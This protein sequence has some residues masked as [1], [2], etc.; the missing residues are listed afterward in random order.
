MV[1]GQKWS[2]DTVD[3]RNPAPADSYR[4]PLVIRFFT[5]GAG[6]LPSTASPIGSVS[7]V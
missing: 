1:F 5:G 3:G 7:Y 6:F 4:H 2:S